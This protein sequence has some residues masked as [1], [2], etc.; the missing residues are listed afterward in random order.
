MATGLP[1]VPVTGRLTPAGV[2][3]LAATF[4]FGVVGLLAVSAALPTTMAA[5]LAWLAVALIAGVIAGH[6]GDAWLAP[7][8]VGTFGL[9]SATLGRLD[10]PYWPIELVVGASL[11]SVAFVIGTA[12]RLRPAPRVATRVVWAGL[13]LA[14]WP[15]AAVLGAGILWI[16]GA[17]GYAFAAGSAEY[18]A[19]RDD[20]AACETPDS[21]FGWPYEAINYDIADDARLVTANTKLTGCTSQGTPAGSEVVTSDGVPIAGWYIPAEDGTA[22]TGP[23]VVLVHGG[24]ANKSGMLSYA[25]AFH[26]SYNLVIIDLRNSGRSGVADSTGGLHE[27]RDLR[28]MID[29]LERTKHPTWLGVMGNSNGAATALAE[30]VGDPRV[31]A[32]ILDS[33]HAGVEHQLGN[34]IETERFLPAWPSAWALIAG[35]GLHLGE[36]LAAVDPVVMIGRVGD[37]PV[38]LT[39]GLA[40]GIDRPA[41]SLALNIEAASAAGVAFEIRVCPGAGHGKVVETCPTGWARWATEFF[42]ARRESTAAP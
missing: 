35:A 33:M 8:S 5:W 20:A 32:L 31:Q 13:G 42:A 38:L 12:A 11:C 26:G 34:L 1:L 10:G 9:I 6:T 36:S 40:D 3:R 4:G 29:W 25:P 24:K 23:S 28:A 37:R 15:L 27:Q 22:A 18:L 16:V 2:L 19:A 17:F 41:D 39:H 14:R 7:A 30:A 21:R